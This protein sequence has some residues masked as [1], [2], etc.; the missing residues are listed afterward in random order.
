MPLIAILSAGVCAIILPFLA[1]RLAAG[2][3]YWDVVQGLAA[4]VATSGLV[5]SAIFALSQYR[6]GRQERHMA[7]FNDLFQRL[8]SNEHVEAR[9][10]VYQ[11]LNL[12]D[13]P[14]DAEI[15]A[16]IAGLDPGRHAAIKL[17]LNALDQLGFL[18]ERGWLDDARTLG[19]L[20]PIVEKT[21]A[22]LRPLVHYERRQR[23]EP[24]YYYHCEY[25]AERCRG[26]DKQGQSVQ[27]NSALQPSALPALRWSDKR[28]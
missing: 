27:P 11:G 25:L 28:L 26:L 19:W 20:S 16:V 12:S 21:W 18:V 9:R 17:C 14:S 23:A 3:K 6:N 13:A 5:G 24:G 1:S 15:E 2:E 10:T 22:K 4:I 8:M 7:L